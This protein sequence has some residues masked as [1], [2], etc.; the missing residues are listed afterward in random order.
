MVFLKYKK[1]KTMVIP[2]MVIP[3]SYT[4]S[5]VVQVNANELS[6]VLQNDLLTSA[7]QLEK[8]KNHE[9]EAFLLNNKLY[10]VLKCTKFYKYIKSQMTA[11]AL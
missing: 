11:C 1:Y 10:S 4:G 7:P 6:I 5:N 8:P 3:I 2:I 9:G